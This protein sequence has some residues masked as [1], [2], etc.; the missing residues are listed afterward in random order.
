MKSIC[1][2]LLAVAIVVFCG[3]AHA[4]DDNAKKIVGIWE[5]TKAGDDLPVG[6]IVEFTKDMKLAASFNTWSA[7]GSINLRGSSVH[8][9]PAKSPAWTS[10]GMPRMFTEPAAFAPSDPFLARA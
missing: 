8:E 7:S 2:S 6:T 4:Q 1:F 3:S 10:T 9:C 5:L